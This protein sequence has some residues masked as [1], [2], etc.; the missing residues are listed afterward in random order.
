MT[1]RPAG[2]TA[3]PR[4]AEE[5]MPLSALLLTLAEGEHR[6]TS[7]AE[8]I[9]HFG[10]RA[11]GALLFIFAIPNLLPL[12]P[13][14]SSVLGLPLLIIAPQLAVGVRRLRIPGPVG[15][16][17][18]DGHALAGACRKAAPW[19]E[20]IEHLTTHRLSFMFGP[21]GEAIIGLLCT[22]L[23]TVMFLP[24]PLGN[25]LPA[26][27]VTVLALGLVQRDGLLIIGGY[28]LTG[29]SAAVLILSGRL[30]VTAIERL[31]A[32]IGLW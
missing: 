17:S 20:R 9:G 27:A 10:P 28:L 2:P 23:A 11:F 30:I 26:A 12:P 6:R 8:I 19:L 31:G 15:R 1:E 25:M 7:V 32:M 24:I 13:G 14:S 4:P 22:L 21:L 18:V 3:D 16:R 5:R 29:A